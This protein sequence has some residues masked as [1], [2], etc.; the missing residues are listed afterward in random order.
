VKLRTFQTKNTCVCCCRISEQAAAAPK[1]VPK[2]EEEEEE[3]GLLLLR[4][5]VIMATFLAGSGPVYG[6][7]AIGK[8]SGSLCKMV[9]RSLFLQQQLPSLLFGLPRRKVH[10]PVATV[11]AA[12]SISP[13]FGG[14]N[15]SFLALALPPMISC[16]L[17]HTHNNNSSM[18]FPL[19][20]NSFETL[21]PSILEFNATI[22]LHS[23]IVISQNS[24]AF[25]TEEISADM[26]IGSPK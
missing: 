18:L 21:L 19:T 2:K 11:R 25:F 9:C 5:L 23:T 7:T 6:F 24:S 13:M 17:T 10:S 20:T 3:E 14:T 26:A 16:T 12:A 1:I 4:Q 15:N 8:G 22:F